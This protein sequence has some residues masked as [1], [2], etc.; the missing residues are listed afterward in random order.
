MSMLAEDYPLY[1]KDDRF[2]NQSLTFAIGVLLSLGGELLVSPLSSTIPPGITVL[3]TTNPEESFGVYCSQ[4]MIPRGT[5]FGPFTGKVVL[6][7][8]LSPGQDN[9]YMWEVRQS[10]AGQGGAIRLSSHPIFKKP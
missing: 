6:P 7:E 8:E 5:R 9:Q 10:R 2:H 1:P 4:T 3:K